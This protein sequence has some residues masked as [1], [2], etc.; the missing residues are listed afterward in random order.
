[1]FQASKHVPEDSHFR[2]LEA[3]GASDVNGTHQ[4]RLHQLLRDA[5]RR[6]SSSW[7]SGSSRTAWATCSRRWTRPRSPTSR[8]SSA[9]SG[10]RAPRT[11]PYGMAEEAVFQTLFPKGAS[12]LRRGHRLA[13]RHPGREARRREAASSASSTR[14]TTRRC[15]IVGDFEPAQARPLVTK[16]FGTLKRGAAVPAVKVEH[17]RRSP[18][19]AAQVVPSRVELPRVYMAWLTPPYFKPGD[20]EADIAAQILGGGR[21]SRLYKKLVY[22]RQ[23]AQDVS[24]CAVVAAAAVGVPDRS[25]GAAGPAPPRS[26]RRRSTRSWR[27]WHAAPP[28][29][30]EVRA[31]AQHDRDRASSA[32]SR[33]SAAWPIG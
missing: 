10:G 19:S 8:T 26:S 20:A 5:C 15:A 27:R 2:L 31:G 3:A 12:L 25:D 14:R 7:R 9:T 16:Y 17:D 18:P 21:S 32:A 11:P 22:E 24:A 30:R 13:R 28:D 33:A 4:L 23:I 29:A 6:T 1:M